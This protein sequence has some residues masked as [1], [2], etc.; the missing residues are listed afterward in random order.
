MGSG[1]ATALPR[2]TTAPGFAR[3]LIAAQFVDVLDQTEL[4]T[5]KLL[6]SELV[7][8]AVL[9]G[10]GAISLRADL[11]EHRLRVEV[12]DQG[13]GFER[14]AAEPTFEQLGGRG[15]QIVDAASSRWGIRKG[16][17]RVWFE[18]ETPAPRAGRG[19]GSD[20][21]RPQPFGTGV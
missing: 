15:L 21:E 17:T 18:L 2:D 5:A 4:D 7:T 8:N 19:S 11:D 1:I 6:V 20:S 13:Y 3:R 16:T 14:A 10:R 9:H 12:V